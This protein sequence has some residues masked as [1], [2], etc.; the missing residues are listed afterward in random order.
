MVHSPSPLTSPSSPRP[1][2][3]LSPTPSLFFHRRP[4]TYAHQP[5]QLFFYHGFTPHFSV[6]TVL[7]TNPHPTPRSPLT[8]S[9]TRI[10]TCRTA[11]KQT[12]LTQD[13]SLDT[14][15]W[16]CYDLLVSKQVSMLL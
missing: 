2:S 3:L 12:T 6:H 8:S 11:S 16:I 13:Y 5:P 1:H 14:G 7:C 9:F 4:S 15:K 10:N